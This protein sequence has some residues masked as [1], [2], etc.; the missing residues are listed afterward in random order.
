MGFENNDLKGIW[1]FGVC[2]QLQ[3]RLRPWTCAT[4]SRP[5]YTSEYEQRSVPHLEMKCLAFVRFRFRLE[6]RCQTREW[7]SRPRAWS[8]WLRGFYFASSKT[9]GP[10]RITRSWNVGKTGYKRPLVHNSN[11]ARLVLVPSFVRA[12]PT[13]VQQ[14][15]VE[16][17]QG[18]SKF[19]G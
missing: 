4:S 7:W 12:W 19:V 8:S 6:R 13:W 1:R 3:C 18:L 10:T 15:T 11:T 2:F 17:R 5:W 9:L 14:S 16:R